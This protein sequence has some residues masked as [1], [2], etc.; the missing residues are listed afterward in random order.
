MGKIQPKTLRREEGSALIESVLTLP[1]ML[2]L[3]AGIIQFGF[4]FNAKVA[5]NSASFEAARQATTSLSPAATA[6]TVA[7]NYAGG[8]LPG[9]KI[10]ERLEVAVS[11]AGGVGDSVTVRVS[12]QVPLF[13]EH[14]LPITTTG[15][16]MK[17]SGW[18]TMYIEERP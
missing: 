14:L 15:G 6:V 13:F 9:W 8:S 11:T 7:E 12:Y 3:L 5:V 16:V 2:L 17:V 4:L 10:G 1:L 18:S